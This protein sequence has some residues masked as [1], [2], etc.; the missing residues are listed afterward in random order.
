MCFVYDIEFFATVL[1]WTRETSEGEFFFLNPTSY[2]KACYSTDSQKKNI[3]IQLL[4]KIKITLFS[5]LG[6]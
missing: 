5:D 2:N 3:W 4:M 6:I 1:L